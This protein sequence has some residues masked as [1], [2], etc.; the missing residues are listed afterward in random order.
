MNKGIVVQI[1]DKEI[2]ILLPTGQFDRITNDGRNCQIGDEIVYSD[3]APTT[4]S[5]VKGLVIAISGLAVALVATFFIVIKLL[6]LSSSDE[7]VAYVSL[8]INPSV[9]MG[10]DES[11]QVRV[12]KGLNA[13][14]EKLI[15]NMKY[16]G[17]TLEEVTQLVLDQAE[18]GVLAAKEADIVVSATVLKE[19]SKLSDIVLAT[20]VKGQVVKHIQKL[21]A[22]DADGFSVLWFAVSP[23]MRQAAISKG[24]SMG[25]FAV[26]LKLKDAG[27]KVSL[28]DYKAK[29]LTALAK[30][31]ATIKSL[32]ASNTSFN[33]MELNQLLEDEKSGKLDQKL[34]DQQKN[35]ATKKPAGTKK[36]TSTPTP[37]S[38]PTP[39]PTPSN[40]PSNKPTT[41]PKPTDKPTKEPEGSNKPT[42]TPKPTPTPKP[43]T[44]PSDPNGNGNGNGENRAP[45]SGKPTNSPTGG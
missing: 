41:T 10:V 15:T 20:K 4:N 23:E 12:M 13:D 36:P 43:T 16:Q 31:Y 1:S 40:K 26:F 39:S 17:K 3:K 7:V 30:E 2:V 8:D 24:I 38:K 6:G 29:S 34:A 5:S 18:K 22:K 11:D 42:T 37:S 27:T 9:E 21:H 33:K 45:Q 14:G 35:E 44:N 19:N 25:K 28:E 32:L